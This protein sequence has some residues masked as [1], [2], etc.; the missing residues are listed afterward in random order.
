MS[1]CLLSTCTESEGVVAKASVAV[2][3]ERGPQ[4]AKWPQG[5]VR[6]APRGSLR[7]ER[8]AG[9]SAEQ[10]RKPERHVLSCVGVFHSLLAHAF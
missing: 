5:G 8:D 10:R 2:S 4:P 6:L 9:L 3:G 1:L 7:E